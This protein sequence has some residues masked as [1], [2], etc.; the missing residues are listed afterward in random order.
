MIQLQINLQW[1]IWEGFSWLPFVAAFHYNKQNKWHL[2]CN[3]FLPVVKV[4]YPLDHPHSSDI[5]LP[6]LVFGLCCGTFCNFQHWAF[7]YVQK[8]L[9]FF[10]LWMVFVPIMKRPQ[11]IHTIARQPK[12]LD[13]ERDSRKMTSKIAPS[14]KFSP[15]LTESHHRI[16]LSLFQN[17]YYEFPYMWI[18]RYWFLYLVC[19][20]V[21]I[22]SLAYLLGP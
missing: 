10:S 2:H 19:L 4:T 20:W 6:P 11:M 15:N 12:W 9:P 5:V 21:F 8:S 16:A 18:F 17:Y 22:A 13:S 14:E 1:K 3:T 7:C